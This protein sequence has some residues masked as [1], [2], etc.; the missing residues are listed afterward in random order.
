MDINTAV[1][2]TGVRCT[3]SSNCTQISCSSG[4][5]ATFLLE[6]QPCR[7]PLSLRLVTISNTTK[8]VS[9]ESILYS[10]QMIGLD[11][12]YGFVALNFTLI[13]RTTRLSIGIKVGPFIIL[14]VV[15]II[16]LCIVTIILS[17]QVDSVSL[18]LQTS[19]PFISSR[20]IPIDIYSC[21]GSGSHDIKHCE[22]NN[23]SYFISTGVG[24][25]SELCQVTGNI[26]QYL[27]YFFTGALGGYRGLESTPDC[28][29][30]TSCN[31][32]NCIFPDRAYDK[33]SILP[34]Q[35]QPALR[36]INVLSNGTVSFEHETN[37][38]EIFTYPPMPEITLNVTF[39]PIGSSRVGL[40]VNHSY[41]NS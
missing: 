11:L 29:P 12:G 31:D 24:P 9:Y 37:S 41:E 40:E 36:M 28:I 26:A 38:S 34:C 27:N 8:K 20:E 19:A 1:N 30:S 17:T 35:S 2:G 14:S 3:L 23:N 25:K 22:N 21:P 15:K 5:T 13:P 10:S 18:D 16:L 39:K 33:I 32:I 6:L 4:A 7:S